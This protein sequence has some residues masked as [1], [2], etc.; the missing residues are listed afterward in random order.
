[1]N[2]RTLVALFLFPAVAGVLRGSA[3]L[4]GPIQRE[5]ILR[6]RP[7]WQALVA[8]YNPKPEA[9]ERLRDLRRE[10]RV[11]VFMGTWCT[12]SRDRVTA[13][14]KVLDLVDN[15]MIHTSCFGVPEDRSKRSRY[16]G[17]RAVEKLPTFIVYVDGK[18]KGRIVETPAKSIEED[19][20]AL[21]EK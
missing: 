6:H 18:E 16:F 8:S 1:M 9:V 10:V 5:D 12:D 14:F 4:L 3:E 13:Y 15:P 19:L 11:E 17:G 21:I 7:E 20:L 2:K